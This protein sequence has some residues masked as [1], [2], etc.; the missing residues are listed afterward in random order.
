MSVRV[1]SS[2][3]LRRRIHVCESRFICVHEEEDTCLS[4]S[5]SRI[6]RCRKLLHVASCCMSQVVACRKFLQFPR[7]RAQRES[8][9]ERQMT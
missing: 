5:S 6:K 8:K 3:Y 9:R 1:A 2:L 7:T 4:E